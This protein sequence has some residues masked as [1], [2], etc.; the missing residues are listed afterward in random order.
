MRL[1][2]PPYS[3]FSIFL[4]TGCA[5]TKVPDASELLACSDSTA[6]TSVNAAPPFIF[7]II[8]YDELGLS[9]GAA[10]AILVDS[11][12]G[13]I[14]TNAHVLKNGVDFFIRLR[15]QW[16]E[17]TT[18]PEW[19][20]YEADIAI[21][22]VR[23]STVPR[24]P[25]PARLQDANTTDSLV[26]SLHYQWLSEGL[27]S[28]T[29]SRNNFFITKLHADYA[30]DVPSLLDMKWL[31]ARQ[32]QRKPIRPRYQFMLYKNFI[33]V[34]AADSSSVLISGMSGG[35]LFSQ[36]GCVIGMPQSL[37]TGIPFNNVYISTEG[38]AIPSAAIRQLLEQVYS[39]LLH[40]H[41]TK[42]L[43]P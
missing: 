3:I 30:M 29:L 27:F 24:L 16:V 12:Y 26:F 36:R 17:A 33:H 38:R 28:R 25:S 5:T 40:T 7:P 14:A 10:N 11:V 43:R 19:I 35:P 23:A 31:E 41:V 4:L 37:K 8:A 32:T 9:V 18:Q 39:T 1:R 13:F 34:R 21:L 42:P 20:F 22:Q 6:I 15:R 2:M